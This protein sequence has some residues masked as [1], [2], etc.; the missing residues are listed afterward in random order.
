MKL[1]LQLAAFYNLIW[2]AWVVL[3]PNHF[4]ELV[5]MDH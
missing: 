5:G 4:F 1:T 3:M 2:G